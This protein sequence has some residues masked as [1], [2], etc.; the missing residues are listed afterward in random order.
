MFHM[1]SCFNLDTEVDIESFREDYLAFVTRMHDVGL[2][3]STGPIGLRQ[4]DTDMDTDDERDHEYF[5]IMSFRDRKQVDAAYA[6]IKRHQE[7][8]ESVHSSVYTKVRN[9]IF[10]C[11]KDID[12]AGQC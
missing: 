6:H 5:V 8:E 2:V 9:P 12:S 11:W 3:E 7:P 4:S 1:L 10:I